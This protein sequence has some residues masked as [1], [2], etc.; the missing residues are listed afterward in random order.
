MGRLRQWLGG[1]QAP[2][3]STRGTLPLPL[4]R[5]RWGA[6]PCKRGGVQPANG[7]AAPPAR[8]CSCACA[9]CGRNVWRGRRNRHGR[10]CWADGSTGW[11]C[12]GPVFGS[13]VHSR[14]VPALAV[15]E[16]CAGI[17][18]AVCFCAGVKSLWLT[19][20]VYFQV[21]NDFVI[22]RLKVRRLKCH[23]EKNAAFHG[24]NPHLRRRCCSL[25]ARRSGDVMQ[26]MA[27]TRVLDSLCC[28]LRTRMRQTCTFLAWHS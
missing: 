2:V 18:A 24:R 7:P 16:R 27:L 25:S 12:P 6:V 14:C 15:E 23:V 11:T 20:Q 17:A 4:P 3:Y 1:R 22:N 28:L 21:N 19:L 26:K 13:T 9:C 5:G 8:A 10:G